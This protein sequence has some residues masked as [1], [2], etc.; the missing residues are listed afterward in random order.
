MKIELSW[1][2]TKG[3][4]LGGEKYYPRCSENSS[5]KDFHLNP[6]FLSNNLFLKKRLEFKEIYK[7]SN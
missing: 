1:S 7:E 3:K 4:Y 6:I 2:N 5:L